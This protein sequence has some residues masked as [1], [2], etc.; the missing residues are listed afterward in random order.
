MDIHELRAAPIGPLFVPA[1]F[2]SAPAKV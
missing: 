2:H 1:V